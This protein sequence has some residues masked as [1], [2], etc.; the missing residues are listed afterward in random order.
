VIS[1]VI[2]LGKNQKYL[3]IILTVFFSFKKSLSQKLE[4][5]HQS[6]SKSKKKSTTKQ[7]SKKEIKSIIRILQRKGHKIKKKLHDM[8]E[9]KLLNSIESDGFLSLG[10][11]QINSEVRLERFLMSISEPERSA[12]YYFLEDEI[13]EKLP[14]NICEKAKAIKKLVSKELDYLSD[15]GAEDNNQ[16]FSPPNIRQEIHEEDVRP[17]EEMFTVVPSNTEENTK[18]SSE[19]PTTHTQGDYASDEEEKIDRREN[20]NNSLPNNH[21]RDNNMNGDYASDEEDGILSSQDVR[22]QRIEER[23]EEIA[24]GVWVVEEAKQNGEGNG[25]S[26]IEI[27]LGARRDHQQ[28]RPQNNHSGSER[29]YDTESEEA[30]DQDLSFCTDSDASETDYERYM[31]NQEKIE[32]LWTTLYQEDIA[33]SHVLDTF[34]DVIFPIPDEY[35]SKVLFFFLRKNYDNLH[36]ER[37]IDMM[38]NHYKKLEMLM[39]NPLNEAKFLQC[40]TIAINFVSSLNDLPESMKNSTHNETSFIINM[41]QFL[42]YYARINIDGFFKYTPEYLQQYNPLL[43]FIVNENELPKAL[44]LTEETL[45]TRLFALFK[46]KVVHKNTSVAEKLMNLICYLTKIVHR[47]NLIISLNKL[48][49]DQLYRSLKSRHTKSIIFRRRLGTV[50]I[51]LGHLPNHAQVVENVEKRVLLDK[52]PALIEIVNKIYQSI[53]ALCSK[54]SFTI[55]SEEDYH[56]VMRTLH[57]FELEQFLEILKCFD[58][59]LIHSSDQKGIIDLA[60]QLMEYGDVKKVISTCS[61]ILILLKKLYDNNNLNFANY[62][63]QIAIYIWCLLYMYNMIREA[64]SHEGLKIRSIKSLTRQSSVDAVTIEENH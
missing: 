5:A 12:F 10:P 45:L 27:N 42:H 57:C 33:E 47:K 37:K 4:S 7:V 35:I 62:V 51:N 21:R 29:S 40:F 16:L 41:I 19:F 22:G 32:A 52:I 31:Q 44:K 23:K 26:Y 58:S 50:L 2:F 20:S 38:K 46:S 39:I 17:A 9:D 34:C 25:I 18:A 30:F 61:Q 1:Q 48:E 8:L 3:D 63:N 43:S 56:K 14:Q 59:H 15:Y 13:L 54:E 64:K 55:F 36:T 28:N 24:H 60:Q 53:Q 11:N 49:L 6:V